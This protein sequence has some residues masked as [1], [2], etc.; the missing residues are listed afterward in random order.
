MNKTIKLALVAALALGATSAFATNGTN[1]IGYGA[2]SRAM[3]GTGISNFNGAESAFANPA[4]ITK[5]AKTTEITIGATLLMPDVSFELDDNAA[6]VFA[7]TPTAGTKDSST[8]GDGMIP[9][10]AVINKVNDNFAWGIALYGTGGMGVDY[11]TTTPDSTISTKGVNDA[12][13]LMRMSIPLA[14]ATNGFS[15]GIA[16]VIEY[17]SLAM[18]AGAGSALENGAA[19]G[20]GATTDIALGFEVGAAY[21]IAGVSMGIDYKS[22]VTHDFKNTFVSLPYDSTN[23][24]ADMQTKLDTPSVL[25]LGVS[26]TMDEHTIALDYKLIGY[27]SALGLEDFLWEDQSVIA[28]GYEYAT[29]DWAARVGY[30]YGANPLPSD[31]LSTGADMNTVA[32]SYM[33][34]PAVTESHFTLGGSYNFNEQ[35]SVDAALMFATGS[36]TVDTP[37]FSQG[38]TVPAPGA[39]EI[40]ATNDQTAITVAL[41][42]GF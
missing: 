3:G 31:I 2:K 39:G 18:S 41:N 28:V 40:T 36:A 12:L 37:D 30:N 25:G 9:A 4:L 33:A 16:P 14:Y 1:L 17:G 6:S 23:P 29:T 7:G 8:A 10:V 19:S 26:Y 32:G 5:S 11:R 38:G 27:G 35:M 15:I 20:G 42:Y 13:L 24:S 21:E 34:F 22:A